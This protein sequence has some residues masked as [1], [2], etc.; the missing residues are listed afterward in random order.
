MNI[1]NTD[2]NKRSSPQDINKEVATKLSKESETYLKPSA[3]SKILKE[4]EEHRI[5]ENMRGKKNVKQQILGVIRRSKY[6]EKPQGYY[7]YYK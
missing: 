1:K 7:S 6:F 2:P 3:L 4:L 5:L